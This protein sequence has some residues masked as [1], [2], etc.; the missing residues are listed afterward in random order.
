MKTLI[1][2]IIMTTL[3]MHESKAQSDK[4]QVLQVV[5]SFVEF[6]DKQDSS[7]MSTI[8][9]K[10]YRAIVHRL[11]GSQETTFMNKSSYLQMLGAKKIGGDKRDVKINYHEV[12]KNN[13]SVS[14]T[15]TGTKS[16]F[17]SYLFLVKTSDDN[18]LIISDL[19]Y[20]ESIN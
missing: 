19:P 1:S 14:A 5:E 2:F 16:V 4:Q 6:A 12:H 20:I 15:F 17:T 13:A 8:L 18:W 7:S 9:H 10:D 3:F 11:F